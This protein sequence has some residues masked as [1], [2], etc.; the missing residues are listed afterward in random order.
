MSIYS[1]TQPLIDTVVVGVLVFVYTVRVWLCRLQTGWYAGR[2][3]DWAAE[4]AE[5]IKDWVTS[6]LPA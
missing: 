5:F 2:Q 3:A 1:I 4:T 6:K